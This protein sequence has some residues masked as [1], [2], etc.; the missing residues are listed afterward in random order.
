MPDY[1][2]YLYSSNHNMSSEIE[3]AEA[4]EKNKRLVVSDPG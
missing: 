3:I 4:D 1:T 2:T